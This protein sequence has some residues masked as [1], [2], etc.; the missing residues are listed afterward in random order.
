MLNADAFHGCGPFRTASLVGTELAAA[1]MGYIAHPW[2]VCHEWRPPG[3][4]RKG[5]G[6]GWAA[7][8]AWG[9]VA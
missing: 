4:E 9:G 8:W 6:E 7:A 2:C 5:A 3:A 1:E